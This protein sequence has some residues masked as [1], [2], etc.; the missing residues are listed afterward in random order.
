[1]RTRQGRAV[2]VM[3][4]GLSLSLA[5]SLAKAEV[6]RWVDANGKT[7]YSDKKPKTSAEDITAEV[8][9]QNL[10]T[11]IDEQRR[12]Q[13]VF[14]PENDADRAYYRQ[15]EQLAAPSKAQIDYCN[16][17]QRYLYKLDGRVVVVDE[18]GKEVKFSERD[19][20]AEVSRVQQQIVQQC[21]S[22]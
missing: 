18:N 16:K 13:Q 5:V 2:I 21:P 22:Q 19:R 15:Q 10:D 17:L 12:M 6:Y 4:L 8:S 1:M 9:K 7:H 11:S 14:R 20:Q 3:T